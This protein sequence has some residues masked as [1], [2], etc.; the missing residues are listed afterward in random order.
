MNT[1]DDIFVCESNK[2]KDLGVNVFANINNKRINLT[3]LDLSYNYIEKL[4]EDQFIYLMELYSLNLNDNDIVAI[5]NRVFINNNKLKLIFLENNYIEKFDFK[6]SRLPQLMRLRLSDNNLST[7]KEGVF[8]YFFIKDNGDED[9]SM[10]YLSIYGNPFTCNCSMEWMRKIKPKI[11]LII[12]WHYKCIDDIPLSC[13]LINMY[14]H[15]EFEND[16]SCTNYT[17]NDCM[18]NKRNK[19][20]K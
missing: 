8:R 1:F 2:L 9:N 11:E 7:L 20:R 13:F 16:A 14:I 12:F 19:K 10:R 6:L 17:F 18:K 5:G 4:H 3:H 15:Y